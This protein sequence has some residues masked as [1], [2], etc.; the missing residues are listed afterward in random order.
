MLHSNYQGVKRLFALPYDGP[1][2]N[3]EVKVDSYQKYIFPRANIENF[4]IEIDDRNFYDEPINDPIRKYDE[5]RVNAIGKRHDYTTGY[6][7]DYAYFDKNYK[8]IAADLS[9]K[10]H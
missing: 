4:N 6:L 3:T 8:L 5:V 9:K 1:N 10:K 7:L 2:T